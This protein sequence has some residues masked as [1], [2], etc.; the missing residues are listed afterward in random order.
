MLLSPF[1]LGLPRAIA[2]GQGDYTPPANQDSRF[3]NLAF[4]DKSAI[5]THRS[6]LSLGS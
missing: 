5:L 6:G 4:G 1:G 3:R 2:K